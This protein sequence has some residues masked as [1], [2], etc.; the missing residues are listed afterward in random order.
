MF[1]N[2]WDWIDTTISYMK[3]EHSIE[4]RNITQSYPIMIISLA[5][6]ILTIFKLFFNNYLSEWGFSSQKK[7]I[8]VDENLPP[9]FSTIIHDQ[10]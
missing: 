2:K 4:F 7:E 3:S 6:I 8:E 1:N 5:S 9:F 10:S